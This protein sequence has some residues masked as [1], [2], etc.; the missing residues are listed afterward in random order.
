MKPRWIKLGNYKVVGSVCDWS[1]E[2]GLQHDDKNQW[3]AR[4]RGE[5]GAEEIFGPSALP[6]L[7]E[8]LI[9]WGVDSE[10]LISMMS[11]FRNSKV[12]DFSERLRIASLDAP[13]MDYWRPNR[14]MRLLTSWA[15]KSVVARCSVDADDWIKVAEGEKLDLDGSSY[16]YEGGRYSTYW[17]FNSPTKG[18]VLVHYSSTKGDSD[19]GEGYIGGIESLIDSPKCP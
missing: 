15:D 3:S 9:E 17:R 5:E 16:S 10:E 12:R 2:I 8:S 4:W 7:Y 18:E 11:G 19:G 1:C 6:E 14:K 13:L